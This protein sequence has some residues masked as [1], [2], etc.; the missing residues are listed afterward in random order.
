VK[1]SSST[2]G[3]GLVVFADD[4]L[5]MASSL[6]RLQADAAQTIVVLDA[7]CLEVAAHK[8]VHIP[9]IW[10]ARQS[11][12]GGL[13]LMREMVTENPGYRLTMRGKWCHMWKRIS[14]LGSWGTSCI[15]GETVVSRCKRWKS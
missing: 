1:R 3:D 10:D 15:Y 12:V 7:V 8:S 9:L 11:G 5:I 6:E 13:R 4:T 14:G 2:G